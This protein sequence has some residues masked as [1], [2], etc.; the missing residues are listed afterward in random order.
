M[1]KH[2]LIKIFG[3]LPMQVISGSA[4]FQTQVFPRDELVLGGLHFYASELPMQSI[5]SLV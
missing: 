3:D 4:H 1:R 2:T 5:N